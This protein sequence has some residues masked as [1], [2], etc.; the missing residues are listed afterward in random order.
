MGPHNGMQEPTPAQD[1]MSASGCF[2]SPDYS[3][4]RLG[5]PEKL[6][7]EF[8]KE[9]WERGFSLFSWVAIHP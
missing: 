7:L 5:E 3:P 6:H 8:P 9:T 1:K 4:M 2:V